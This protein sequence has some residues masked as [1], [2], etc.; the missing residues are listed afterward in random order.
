M[1]PVEPM[2]LKIE[3]QKLP[4]RKRGVMMKFLLIVVG[5]ALLAFTGW[6]N[7]A[8]NGSSDGAHARFLS[9]TLGAAMFAGGVSMF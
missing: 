6:H 2:K 1:A 3:K 4:I 7:H 8:N 9:M 5:L